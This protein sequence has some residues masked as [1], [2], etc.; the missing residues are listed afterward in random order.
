MSAFAVWRKFRPVGAVFP[1][2]YETYFPPIPMPKNIENFKYNTCQ[3]HCLIYI[4]IINDFESIY[5]YYIFD[6]LKLSVG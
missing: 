5:R 3:N 4:D 6:L 2:D 1:D